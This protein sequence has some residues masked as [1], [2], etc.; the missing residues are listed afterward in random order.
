VKKYCDH[1]PLYRQS[2][3]LARQGIEISRGTM[4]GWVGRGIAALN[5]ITD[6]MRE[7]ILK[8][9]RLFVDETTAKVLAPGTGKTKTGHLWVMVR[10]DRAHAGADPPVAVY[11]YMPGRGAM[12][13]TKLLAGYRGMLQ[14]D[15]WQAYDQ[16]GK[17]DRPGGPLTIAY[18]W[19]HLRRGFID[20]GK[21]APVAQ[22]ALQRIAA[23]YAIEKEIRGRPPTERLAVRQDRTRPLVEALH[24]WFT[25]MAPRMM[26]GSDTGEAMKYALRRW[27]GMTAFLRDGRIEMDNNSAERAMRPV[28]LQRKNALFAGHELGAEHWAAIF[29]LVET[30]KMCGFRRCRPPIPI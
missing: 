4:A 14:V 20:A 1:L 29:T 5:R 25:A 3:I 23:I 16:F 9:D 15:A 26:A 10:D 22:D 6:R 28:A 30:C 17:A 27:D 19:A 24:N 13:A 12:W 11:S 21:D 8:S 7:D 18:C 2:Q